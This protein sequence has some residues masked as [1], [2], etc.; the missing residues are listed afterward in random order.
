MKPL[1][2]LLAVFAAGTLW[3]VGAVFDFALA[4]F[5]PVTALA[6]CSGA[7]LRDP[8]G[9][10][11]AGALLVIPDL[12]INHHY[13][14]EHGYAWDLAGMAVRV[15]A[16]GAACALGLAVARKRNPALLF[17]GAI[18]STL[19][20]YLVTNTASWWAD[21]FYARS[22]V[23]WWQALTVGHPEFPPSLLFLR[24]ALIGDLT[25]TSLCAALAVRLPATLSK[26]APSTVGM[27]S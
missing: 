2:L 15:G 26:Q 17:G 1:L 27:P 16:L 24:N 8:R 22:V 6:F 14:T 12:W 23:G 9:W 25:F 13:A 3:R 19:A 5:A 11:V 10:W 20:F 7:F 18:A 21:P 4:N